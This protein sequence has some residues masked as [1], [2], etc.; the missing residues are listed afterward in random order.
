MKERMAIIQ[1]MGGAAMLS[2]FT[3]I[4][5]LARDFLGT[6]EF[7]ITLMVG[8]YAAASFFSSYIFGR[9]GD[10]YGRRIILRVGLL[11]AIF[12]LGFLVFATSPETLFII[13]I[14]NG[15]CFGMYPGALAAYAYE[16]KL[17]MGRFATFGALG[18][19][20]GTVLAG[21]VAAFEIYYAFILASFFFVL[22]FAS[23]LTLPRI[24]REWID[25]P[26]FPV[27][28]FKRNKSV[29]IAVFI[30][31]SSAAA[32]WSLW[33]LFL[34]DL[35]G[36]YLMIGIIQATNSISQVVFMLLLTDRLN[37]RTLISIGLLSSMITFASLLF[38][39]S[40]WEV[41]P[42]Q[43]ILGL[44][45]ACLYVGSLKYLTENNEDR[46]TASGLLTSILSLSTI[47]GPIM[48]TILYTLWPAYIPLFLNAVFLCLVAFIFFRFSSK[49]SISFKLSEGD[50][51]QTEY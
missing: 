18:W 12:S 51:V 9:A 43:I 19:G 11:L 3:Y 21:Y 1:A 44:A 7:F 42:S 40:I 5:I 41:L 29:Y 16:S 2:S 14:T 35:G 39:T 24:E 20:I 48:A 13:R 15:F 30:R 4:P 17:E 47:M 33:S 49:D 23:A 37:Y 32:I 22:A 38:V 26:L 6:D 28:T 10:I 8:C 25:V 50:P 45:W 34:V 31:H 46:S 36:D 27:E